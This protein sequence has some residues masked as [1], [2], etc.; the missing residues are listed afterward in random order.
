MSDILVIS[1]FSKLTQAFRQK[2]FQHSNVSL[3]QSS[4]CTLHIFVFTCHSMGVAL[5]TD[6]KL[7]FGPIWA[8]FVQQRALGSQSQDGGW[9]M[10]D[11]HPEYW[12]MHLVWCLQMFWGVYNNI[13]PVTA[14]PLRCSYHLMRGERRPLWW[15]PEVRHITQY[16]RHHLNPISLP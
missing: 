13:P 10:T 4:S 1:R 3:W 8:N 11:P 6:G 5:H 2:P 9:T 15:V 7:W 12:C 14:L 16:H